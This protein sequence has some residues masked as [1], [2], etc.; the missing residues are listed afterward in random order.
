[1]VVEKSLSL[2]TTGVFVFPPARFVSALA[3]GE[4]HRRRAEERRQRHL[5]HQQPAEV[6]QEEADGWRH[7]TL[8]HMTWVQVLFLGS[9]AVGE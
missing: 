9:T 6:G 5:L 2:H 8:T 1:M 4:T 7:L 3:P